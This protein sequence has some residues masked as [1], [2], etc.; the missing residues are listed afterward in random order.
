[1]VSTYFWN[2]HNMPNLPS[3]TFEAFLFDNPD[4]IRLNWRLY[5]FD[6]RI[7]VDEVIRF[8]NLAEALA[9][10]SVRLQ[11]PHNVHEV[12]RGVRAKARPQ[13]EARAGAPSGGAP[14]VWT[15]DA[16]DLIAL[17]GKPEISHFG[18]APPQ[19]TD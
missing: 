3:Q 15:R 11:L 13:P 6:D 19:L 18:Y 4:R 2:R 10:L 1:M 7:I 8:E 17:L 12:M 9:Q 16:I 14:V 5:T